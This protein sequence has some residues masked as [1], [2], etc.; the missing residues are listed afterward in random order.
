MPPMVPQFL[1][2][3]HITRDHVGA[4]VRSGGT[5]SY[6]G[7][8]AARLGLRTAV[9]TSAADDLDLPPQMA[10][11]DVHRQPAERT[12]VFEHVWHG[13]V[14]EQYVRAR[15]APIRRD[16]LPPAF[17]EVPI[18]LFGP[19]VGEVGDDLLR[20]FPRALRGA[21]LQG[22]L[23][24]TDAQQHMEAIDAVAWDEVPVLSAVQAAFLS[25]E[26]VGSP[27]GGVQPLFNRW[28]RSVSVLAVTE[29]DGG[30]RVAVNGRW[31]RIG[32]FPAVEVDG[33]GAGDAFA[34]GFLIRYHETADAAEAARFAA[35]VASFVVEAPGING[36]PSRPLVEARLAAHPEVRLRPE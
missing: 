28:A 5:P 6:A 22:W 21:T 27:A 13:R 24:T 9:L 18:V 12:T 15:A 4:D 32:A 33:T 20:A 11:L 7:V 23:R 17:A 3:G 10:E 35:S 31:H 34:A 19:L 2:V 36:T 26:D 14:R 16:A 25:V 29:G 8:V 1:V 30:A